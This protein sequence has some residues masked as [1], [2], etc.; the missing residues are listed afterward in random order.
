[1]SNG[2]FSPA[3]GGV[4]HFFINQVLASM[5][6]LLIL[7]FIAFVVLL[8]RHYR[9][10]ILALLVKLYR[11]INPVY[12]QILDLKLPVAPVTEILIMLVVVEIRPHDRCGTRVSI[13]S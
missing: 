9:E 10:L 12:H 6:P 13:F 11:M 1:M 5:E 4:Y 7:D 2:L 3:N 8:R